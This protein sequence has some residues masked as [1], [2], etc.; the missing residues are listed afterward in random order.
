MPAI[1][2]LIFK[3]NNWEFVSVDFNFNPNA[4]SSFSL[5]EE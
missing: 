1:K 2:L 4:D 3:T 5:Q